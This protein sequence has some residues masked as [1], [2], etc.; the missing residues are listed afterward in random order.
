[1]IRGFPEFEDQK[2]DFSEDERS[3]FFYIRVQ[4]TQW[5]LLKYNIMFTIL[6]NCFGTE[7][8]WAHLPC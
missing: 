7:N 6:P 2:I 1:M 3:L 5:R 4:N 8:F